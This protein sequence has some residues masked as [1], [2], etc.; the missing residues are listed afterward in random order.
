MPELTSNATAW[1]TVISAVAM[2][3]AAFATACAA[4]AAS[5][6][7]TAAE[8]TAK[9]TRE[10]AEAEVRARASALVAEAHAMAAYI[11]LAAEEAIS[12]WRGIGAKSG[13]LDNSGIAA[14]V[15]SLAKQKT[16][17]EEALL[18]AKKSGDRLSFRPAMEDVWEIRVQFEMER[19]NLESAMKLL[20]LDADLRR[21][22]YSFA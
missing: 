7:A 18:D 12:Q 2:V 20:S 1:A 11:A 17:A 4:K 6:S 5:R 13:G 8:A 15:A 22:Q 9:S 21:R 14:T 10:M 19:V 3:V 16:Q